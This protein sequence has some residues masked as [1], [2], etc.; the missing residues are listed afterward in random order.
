MEYTSDDRNPNK[1]VYIY[2]YIHTHIPIYTYAYIYIYAHVYICVYIYIYIHTYIYIYMGYIHIYI[3]IHIIYIY[4]YGTHP[5]IATPPSVT[6]KPSFSAPHRAVIHPVRIAR[7]PYPRFVPRVGLPRNLFLIGSLTA[8]LRFSKG[9]VR[10]DANLGL[11][12][13]CTHTP[14][15]K[16]YTDFIL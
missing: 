12:T 3:Y 6:W 11:R 9:W 5:T 7:I 16:S 13:G 2:I 15:Q 4:I 10:K 8:A 1:Y 14:A